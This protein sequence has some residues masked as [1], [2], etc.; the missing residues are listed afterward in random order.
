MKIIS[1]SLFLILIA[2]I[3]LAQEP[4]FKFGDEVALE[5]I[6]SGKKVKGEPIQWIQ[7]KS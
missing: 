1:I 4:L 5:K 7:L 3:M 6:N 2:G